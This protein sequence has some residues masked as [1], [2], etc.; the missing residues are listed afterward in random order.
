MLSNFKM[1]MKMA[2]EGFDKMK[3]KIRNLVFQTA[4][5]ECFKIFGCDK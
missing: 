3:V 1:F 4:A 2:L 5:L